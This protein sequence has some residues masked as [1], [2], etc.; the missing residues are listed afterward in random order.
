[1]L[2]ANRATSPFETA[3][4][5]VE[6]ARQAPALR[7]A[8][9]G[10]ALAA[11]VIFVAAHFLATSASDLAEQM[12]VAKG[13][14]GLALL[15]VITSLPEAIVSLA[16]IRSGSY[17]LAVGNLLGSNCFNLVIF[18]V[19]DLVDGPGSVL[20]RVDVSLVIGALFAILLIGLAVLDIV[21]RAERRIWLV[22][23]GPA[24]IVV[25][26]MLGLYFVFQSSH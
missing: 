25:T 14:L 24:L 21:H 3:T 13:F 22:E 17:D 11:G 6:H 1:V 19:L 20:A 8:V 23:P 7:P 15:A 9:I 2:Y 26:Y 12:G 4:E 5:S 10:F 18:V 16:S